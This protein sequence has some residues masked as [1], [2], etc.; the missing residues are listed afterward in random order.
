[1]IFQAFFPKAGDVTVSLKLESFFPTNTLF[2][3]DKFVISFAKT[4]EDIMIK[5]KKPNDFH[6]HLRDNDMLKITVI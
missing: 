1:M 2:F 5:I 4:L 6:H 3:Q